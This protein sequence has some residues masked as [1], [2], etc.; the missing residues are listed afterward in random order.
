MRKGFTLIELLV[1]IAIIAILAALLLPALAKA[2]L[3]AQRTACVSALHQMEIA[4]NL[5]AT[6]SV[7]K[8]P[9]LNGAATWSWDIPADA[10][11]VMMKSGLI[12]KSFYC[13][14]TAPRFTDTQNWAGLDGSGQGYCLWN[15]SNWPNPPAFNIVGYA[16]A[17]SGPSSKTFPTNQNATLQAESVQNFPFAGTSTL[18]GPADRVLLA[19]VVISGGATTPGYQNPGNGYTAVYGGF[20]WPPGGAQYPHLSGHLDGN[21]TPVGQFIGYKDGHTDWQLFGDASPRSG[22]GGNPY[23]WW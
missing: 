17:F 9:V 4:I 8:L 7:D 22:G 2:K 20:V 3:K 10:I 12:R 19:D 11:K 1:V 21:I 13:P 15:F 14:T 6:T 18:Y 5:Y 23:F 16:F